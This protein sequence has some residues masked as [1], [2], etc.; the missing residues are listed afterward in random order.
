MMEPRDEGIDGGRDAT[1]AFP[2]TRRQWSGMELT[3]M[4]A[5]E[6]PIAGHVMHWH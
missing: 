3:L 4:G 5:M 2:P 6:E 1:S